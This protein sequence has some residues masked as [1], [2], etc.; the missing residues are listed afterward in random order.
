[1]QKI[2]KVNMLKIVPMAVARKT[3]ITLH[4]NIFIELGALDTALKHVFYIFYIF[5]MHYDK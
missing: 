2:I 3:G 5:D 4:N 1:M